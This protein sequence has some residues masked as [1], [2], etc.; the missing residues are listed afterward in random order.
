MLTIRNSQIKAFE[1]SSFKRFEDLM[2]AHVQQ[3]FPHH[4]FVIQDANIRATIQYGYSRAQLYGL[5]TI[6]NVCLYINN[7]LLLG[8][9]FDS[10]PQ[11]PLANKILTDKS[12]DDNDRIDAL[13]TAVLNL[14]ESISGP[15]SMYIYRS[16]LF[17]TKNADSLY[18][19]FCKSNT[20]NAFRHFEQ[21]FKTKYEVIGKENLQCLVQYGRRQAQSYNIMSEPKILIYIIFMFMLGSGFDR[22]PQF[23]WTAEILKSKSITSE[24]EKIAELYN[25]T[26]ARL[27]AGLSRQ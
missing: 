20:D 2:V 3:Y 23:P 12:K 5:K 18:D 24:G 10:D 22:D 17:I 16:V 8:S 27:Q 21:L 15:S 11:Y 1:Q 6:R 25:A 13:S 4:Y 14:L 26:I 7:M 19:E 9:N